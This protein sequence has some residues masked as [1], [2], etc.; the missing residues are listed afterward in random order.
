MSKR[1]IKER[2]YTLPKGM[3]ATAG[4]MGTA[5][6]GDG[7]T[8]TAGDR[9]T[10]KSGPVGIIV[11]RWWDAKAVRFRLAVGYVGE[12]G[13]KPDTFYQCDDAGKLIEV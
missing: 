10:A 9:G 5:T 8:A 11:I 4:D 3:T 7:G 12:D 1:K 6:A 13:I 2:E